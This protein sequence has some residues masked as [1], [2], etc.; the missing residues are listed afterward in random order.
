MGKINCIDF[1]IV[2]GGRSNYGCLPYGYR[3]DE[4]GGNI[5]ACYDFERKVKA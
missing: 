5:E 3:G 1:W 2:I 4:K